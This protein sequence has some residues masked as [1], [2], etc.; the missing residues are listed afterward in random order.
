MPQKHE[1]EQWLRTLRR[2]AADSAAGVGL[3]TQESALAWLAAA[4]GSRAP[5]RRLSTE[6][7]GSAGGDGTMD[8]DGEA[9]AAAGA[10][11]APQEVVA[12]L[13]QVGGRSKG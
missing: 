1:Q 5:P 6:S 3:L 4:S 8:V 10:H 12:Q 2:S 11:E 9:A 13:M 7:G